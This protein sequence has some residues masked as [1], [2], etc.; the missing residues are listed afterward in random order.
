MKF[1]DECKVIVETL[2]KNEA[3]AFVKFL[4]SEMARHQMDIDNARDLCYTVINKYKL[5][6]M[7]E[8]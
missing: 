1:D 3:R 2:N 8:G 4:K 5:D 6:D 7:W